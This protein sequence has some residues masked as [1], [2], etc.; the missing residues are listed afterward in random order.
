MWE[1]IHFYSKKVSALGPTVFNIFPSEVFLI[2]QNAWIVMLGILCC[3][4]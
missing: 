3:E 1:E 4:Y 2:P